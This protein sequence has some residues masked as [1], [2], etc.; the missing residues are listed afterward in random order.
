LFPSYDLIYAEAVMLP[1]KC[2]YLG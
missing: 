1:N 2:R